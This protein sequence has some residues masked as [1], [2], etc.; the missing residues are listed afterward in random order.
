MARRHQYESGEGI[1]LVFE[2]VV[3]GLIRFPL[4]LL[5]LVQGAEL[6]LGV[7]IPVHV[8]VPELMRECEPITV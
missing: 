7:N 3:I 4:E 5:P 2:P 1:G 8:K 6:E